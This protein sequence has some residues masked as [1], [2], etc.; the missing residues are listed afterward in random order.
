MLAESDEEKG[1]LEREVDLGEPRYGD[2]WV[3]VSKDDANAHLTHAAMLSV[4]SSRLGEKRDRE[5]A[6]GVISDRDLWAR[7]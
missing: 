4:L 5:A 2:E 1:R 6:A 3:M 7:L